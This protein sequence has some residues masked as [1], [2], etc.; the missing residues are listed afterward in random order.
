MTIRASM[1]SA[2]LTSIAHQVPIPPLGIGV[3]LVAMLLPLAGCNRAGA[4][5]KAAVPPVAMTQRRGDDIV[6]P[7]SS[8]LRQ[9]LQV[10]PVSAGAASHNVALPAVVEA[11]PARTVNIVPPLA[12]RLTELRVRLGDAVRKGQI[13]AVISSPDLAQAHADA[14]KARDARE[15]ADRALQRARGV[16]EAGA[17]AGKDMEQAHS[18]FVQAVAEA[19]RAEARLQALGADGAGNKNML[20]ISAPVAGIVTALNSGAGSYL[21]DLSA[22]LMTIANLDQ[23]WI[24]ASVPE[25]LVASVDKGQQAKVSFAAYPNQVHDGVVG[26]VSAVLEADTRRNK[27]RIAM[28]NADGRLKPNMYATVSLAVPQTSGLSVPAAALLMNNDNTTV[29][30]EVAPWTF[31]R[32]TVETGAEDGDSVRIVSGLR[33]GERVVVRGG[34]LL[35]D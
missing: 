15:L 35:N 31:A 10:A 27:A 12:G 26:F 33:A 17:N 1:F 5:A 8:P 11:D 34:V 24:A 4:G 13:L 30:V 9:R 3:L 32:R 25:N 16:N 19:T 2:P 20:A 28:S 6:V 14:E 29:F 21:N 23:V 7:A 22:P 18:A